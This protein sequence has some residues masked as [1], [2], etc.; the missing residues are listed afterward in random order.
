V[1]VIWNSR[2]LNGRAKTWDSAILGP[3]VPLYEGTEVHV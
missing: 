3:S 1:E 2:R